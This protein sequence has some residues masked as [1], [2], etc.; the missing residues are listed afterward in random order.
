MSV[1]FWVNRKKAVTLV[2]S[3]VQNQLNFLGVL[4]FCLPLPPSHSCSRE[5]SP[6][7]PHLVPDGGLLCRKLLSD[8]PSVLGHCP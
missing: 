4:G 7:Y 6:N 3:H 5:Q 8:S 1:E 2:N